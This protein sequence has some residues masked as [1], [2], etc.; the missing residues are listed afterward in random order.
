LAARHGPEPR[1]KAIAVFCGARPGKRPAFASAAQEL[2]AEMARRK[3][4]LIYGGGALGMMGTL[5][6]AVLQGGG[7]VIGVLPHGL[8]RKEF[9]HERLTALHMVETMHERKGRMEQLAD[10]FL[11]LPG[12]FGTL[13]ELFEI[14]TWAQVG[15]HQ[16]PIGLLDTDGYWSGL[17]AQIDRAVEEG[18]VTAPLHQVMVI[19]REP[20]ALVERLLQHQPPDPYVKWLR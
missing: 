4:K 8:A 6:D 12:G 11:A 13:D 7:E 2:G 5:A 3:L 14:A 19:E 18:F 15:L 16:K 17:K 9:A 1:L 20:A 10:G